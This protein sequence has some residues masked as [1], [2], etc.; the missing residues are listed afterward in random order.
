MIVQCLVSAF[1]HGTSG[2]RCY[3]L[4]FRGARAPALGGLRDAAGQATPAVMPGPRSRVE[5][6]V[7]NGPGQLLRHPVRATRF[8][9][10]RHGENRHPMTADRHVSAKEHKIE[11]RIRELRRP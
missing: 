6:P 5:G 7:Q 8:D 10:A 9:D 2:T 11:L 4:W 3:P 1:W